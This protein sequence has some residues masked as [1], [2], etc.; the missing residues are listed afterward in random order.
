MSALSINNFQFVLTAKERGNGKRWG[1]HKRTFHSIFYASIIHQAKLCSARIQA[2][3]KEA[4]RLCLRGRNR[5]I[6]GGL[7]FLQPHPLSSAL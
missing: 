4:D 2:I 1:S 3:A 7:G 6:S 5:A